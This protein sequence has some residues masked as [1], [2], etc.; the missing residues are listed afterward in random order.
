MG[1]IQK[2]YPQLLKYFEM[3]GKMKTPK[4]PEIETGSE[5]PEAR[6]KEI[7][8]EEDAPSANCRE[9]YVFAAATK[10]KGSSCKFMS[11]AMV[12]ICTPASTDISTFTTPSVVA[13]AKPLLSTTA[14]SKDSVWA[15]VEFKIT[16]CRIKELV[17]PAVRMLAA[18]E[19]VE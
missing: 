9:A 11:S 18:E 6:L 10:P 12:F 19:T 17:D 15:G 1:K 13:V 2:I 16:P 4:I 5:S 8:P 14:V 7:S 3:L